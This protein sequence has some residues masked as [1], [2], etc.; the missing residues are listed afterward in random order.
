VL[1]Q[2]IGT[3]ESTQA[4]LLTGLNWQGDLPNPPVNDIVVDVVN[5][6]VVLRLNQSG[7]DIADLHTSYN[8]A[9]DILTITAASAGDI[10]YGTNTSGISI[11]NA[12]DAI[13][14]DL[15]TITGFGGFSVS[16][17]AGR[18]SIQ[19]GSGGINLGNVSAGA[20]AQ[21]FSINTGSDI[22]DS[23]LVGYDVSAKGAGSLSFNGDVTLTRDIAVSTGGAISF[24]SKL[25]GA[26]KLS[27]SAGGAISLS[28]PVG[29][30]AALQGL[31]FTAASSVAINDALTLDGTGTSGDGLV[32]GN[33]VNNVVFSAATGSNARTI[34]SFSGS[35]IR[36]LGGS[37]GSLL[38]NITSTNNGT[39]LRIDPGRYSNSVLTKNFFNSNIGDGILLSG[40]EGLTDVT[41]LVAPVLMRAVGV[42]RPPSI[43][44]GLPGAY[45]P[46]EPNAVYTRC[47][48]F[49][50][51]LPTA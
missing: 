28:G 10:A 27:L 5:N 24:S 48:P 39:G 43:A 17:G 14:V 38:R 11:N 2:Q 37:T 3:I 35:G 8:S 46:G 49:G 44:G 6:Q 12:T 34:R 40:C 9:S 15:R 26:R 18:D 50:A 29:G 33:N 36:F 7:V 41:P 19:I 32:I 22:N 45:A 25:N 16:G 4:D 51:V 47:T 1:E 30:T 21:S 42:I 31:T 13:A 23:I 20:A